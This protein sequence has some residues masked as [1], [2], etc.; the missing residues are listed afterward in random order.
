MAIH[1]GHRERIKERFIQ[2]GLDNFD[3][4]LVLELL[5]YYCIP[6]VDTNEIAHRLIN[7]FGSL[8][9][10][11]EATVE[12]LQKVEG[13][14]K[15]AATFLTLINAASRYY[16]VKKVDYA[17]PLTTVEQFGEVLTPKFSGRR[18]EMIYLLC[19]DSKCKMICCRMVGEG[20]VNCAGVSVRKIAEQALAVNATS[21]VLSHNHPSGVAVPSGEDVRTTI[22][23]A[24]ALKAVGVALLDHIIVADD[25]YTSMVISGCY[26]FEDIDI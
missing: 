17:K 9:N 15:N 10:V 1:D 2:E 4:Y 12:E 26:R 25:D 8:P 22:Q 23:A 18:N 5:L 24:K 7:T 16:Q 11:L 19:L 13:I 20:S 3:D 14:G 6:R 21:V